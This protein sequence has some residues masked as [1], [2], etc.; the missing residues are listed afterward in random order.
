MIIFE[1]ILRDSRFLAHFVENGLA[2][3]AVQKIG[4]TIYSITSIIVEKDV[5]CRGADP[6][7]VETRCNQAKG[8]WTEL[9]WI[10]LQGK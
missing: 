10:S 5:Y 4:D 8:A 2:L 9:N 7:N 1:G 3:Y 6:K